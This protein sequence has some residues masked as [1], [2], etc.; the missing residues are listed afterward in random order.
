M[1]KSFIKALKK[2]MILFSPI[3]FALPI[4]NLQKKIIR[5]AIIGWP[6]FYIHFKYSL[7]V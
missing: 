2:I 7:D 5:S 6:A 3:N 4:A 1:S